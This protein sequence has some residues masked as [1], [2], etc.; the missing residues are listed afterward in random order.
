M[1]VFFF[2][3]LPS[4]PEYNYSFELLYD[5]DKGGTYLCNSCQVEDPGVI[6]LG[7]LE[8]QVSTPTMNTQF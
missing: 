5:F 7:V 2:F 8:T 3:C 1:W 6:R 4:F